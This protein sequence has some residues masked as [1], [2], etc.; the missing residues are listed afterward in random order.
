[1][2]IPSILQGELLTR[3]LQGAAVGAVATIIVGFY[4]D[5]G[6]S[7]HSRQDGEGAI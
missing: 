4:C 3:P 7:Q 5:G 6:R 2:Q 1:M